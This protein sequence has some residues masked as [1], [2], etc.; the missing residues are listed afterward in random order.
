[1]QLATLRKF[2]I[3]PSHMQSPGALATGS[4][5]NRSSRRRP[6]PTLE[7]ATDAGPTQQASKSNS[8]LAMLLQAALA[9]TATARLQCCDSNSYCT[10]SRPCC[11]FCRH[12]HRHRHSGPADSCPSRASSR[13]PNVHSI[14]ARAASA[15]NTHDSPTTKVE[16]LTVPMGELSCSHSSDALQCR[17]ARGFG[18]VHLPLLAF[19]TAEKGGVARF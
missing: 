3:L 14:A 7:P 6:G 16:I 11:A 18:S 19:I 4:G 10:I 9:T 17:L 2:Y 8:L 15:F 12:K 5:P 1:M 13:H